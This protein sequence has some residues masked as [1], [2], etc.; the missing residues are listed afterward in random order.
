MAENIYVT[1]LEC[2]GR[3]LREAIHLFFEQRDELAVHV[4]GSAAYG[5][6]KD[7]TEH[8]E[9][10]Q[11]A[12][13]VCS[14]PF[15]LVRDYHRGTLPRS[16]QSN[17]ALIKFI[18]ELAQQHSIKASHEFKDFEIR[19]DRTDTGR[20]WRENNKVANFLKHAQQDPDDKLDMGSVNNLFLLMQASASYAGLGKI[21]EPEFDV[22]MIYHA[23]ELGTSDIFEEDLYREI[24]EFII[25]EVSSEERLEVCHSILASLL[26]SFK[27]RGISN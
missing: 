6:L 24:S 11:A 23:V 13:V 8:N 16:F 3:L 25:N 5:I 4:I 27:R 21:L 9:R 7:L 15:Y 26:D 19:M 22:L 10:N 12:E 2:A 1:K 14:V 17:R 18:E 20:Y